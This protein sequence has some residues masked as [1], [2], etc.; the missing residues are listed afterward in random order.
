MISI[1]VLTY[2]RDVMPCLKSIKDNTFN[3]HEIILVD[4]SNNYKR[5]YDGYVDKYIGL[6]DNEGVLARNYGKLIAKY[7]YIACIDDDVTV[8]SGWDEVLLN[9][10][11]ESDSIVGVGPCGHYA[12]EDLSNYNRLGGTPGNYVD[13]LTGYCWMYKNVPEGLM[14]WDYG[15]ST[16]HDETYI[17]FLM[18]EKGYKF[19]MTNNVCIH[20]SQRGGEINWDDHN[21]KIEKIKNRFNV[22]DLHLEKYND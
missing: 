13:V 14:P 19:K 5:K 22:K 20:N 10:I 2:N 8:E 17:Q 1:V 21:S 16:W 6:K 11:Q 15:I 9:T 12:F 7:D 3:K 4:N 18:R